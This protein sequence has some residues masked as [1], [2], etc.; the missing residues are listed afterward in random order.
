MDMIV[1]SKLKDIY[2][3]IAFIYTKLSVIYNAFYIKYQWY[4]FNTH[5]LF[6]FSLKSYFVP[7][8]RKV[9]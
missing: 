5:R 4:N 2:R 6:F 3:A 7:M 1:Q 8:V 9:L